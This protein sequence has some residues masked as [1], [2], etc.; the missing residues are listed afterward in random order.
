MTPSCRV[1]IHDPTRSSGPAKGK[2]RIVWSH[3]IPQGRRDGREFSDDSFDDIA[4]EDAPDL[5]DAL[6]ARGAQS[7]ARLVNDAWFVSRANFHGLK[8]IVLGG[9]V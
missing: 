4:I 7:A 6:L 1:E 2:L 9:G 5:A 3:M 8:N